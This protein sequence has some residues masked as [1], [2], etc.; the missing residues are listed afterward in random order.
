MTCKTVE[1]RAEALYGPEVL[2]AVGE[3]EDALARLDE[4]LRMSPVR[5]GFIT[6]THFHDAAASLWLAGKLVH[7][8]DLVLHDA[9]MD[10]RAPT[11]ELTRAHAV[12]RARRRIAG[13]PPSAWMSGG[14]D[15]LRGQDRRDGRDEADPLEPG[16][17][18]PLPSPDD[19]LAAEFLAIDAAIERSHRVLAGGF[20]ASPMSGAATDQF[21][22]ELIYDPEHDEKALFAEWRRRLDATAALPPTLAAAITLDDWRELAPAE[23]GTWLGPQLVADLLRSRGKARAH[24]PCVNVGLR[25]VPW[26]L[27]RR[28][29]PEARLLANLFGLKKA[30]DWGLAECDRLIASRARLQ[31]GC[32]GRRRNSRLPALV[33]FV[34]AKPFVT[35]NM[36]AVELGVSARAA[37]DMMTALNL[38][39]LTGRGRFRAWG[40]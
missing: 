24:L 39:E 23:H 14:L 21:R 40:V 26:E 9:A 31:R 29:D 34:L 15:A 33:D 8:E 6:R 37:R 28:K 22:R 5:E 1:T 12:L 17:L 30:A 25:A 3:A 13:A 11:H 20:D 2:A 36:A 27:R 35:A 10:L 18:A 16:M 7:V 38:R 4:R 32:R 19:P